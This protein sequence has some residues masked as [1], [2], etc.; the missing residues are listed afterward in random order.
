[1]DLFEM[2]SIA[3]NSI[4]FSFI[5]SLSSKKNRQPESP[6][7]TQ[8]KT[9]LYLSSFVCLRTRNTVILPLTIFHLNILNFLF[10]VDNIPCSIFSVIVFSMKD[11]KNTPSVKFDSKFSILFL[12]SDYTPFC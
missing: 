7:S 2:V 1:M 10:P 8:N 11:K 6:A 5:L 3:I 4:Y 9:N 12:S